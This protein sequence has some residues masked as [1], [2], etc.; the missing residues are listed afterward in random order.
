MV[1]VDHILWLWMAEGFVS[2]GKEMMEDVAE[3]FLNELIR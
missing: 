3:G 2:I 1:H